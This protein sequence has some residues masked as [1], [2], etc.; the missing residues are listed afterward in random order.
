MLLQATQDEKENDAK[1]NH[2]KTETLDARVLAFF[3]T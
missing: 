2:V 1:E 3:L